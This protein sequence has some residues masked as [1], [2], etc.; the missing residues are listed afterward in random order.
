MEYSV[1]TALYNGLEYTKAYLK[2]LEE[3]MAGEDY[4]LILID[5]CS[6]DGTREFLETLRDR[7]KTKIFLNK[8]NMGFARSNNYAAS[9]A[10]GKLLLLLNNDIILTPGWLKPMHKAIRRKHRWMDHKRQVSVVGNIQKRMDDGQ[11]DHA[12]VYLSIYTTP[13]HAF[14]N[15]ETLPKEKYTPWAAATAA[16]WLVEAEFFRSLGGFDERYVNGMEDV[17]FCL[18]ALEKGRVAVVANQSIIQHAVSASRVGSIED[19]NN[20]RKLWEKWRYPLHEWSVIDQARYTWIQSRVSK[21]FWA[22]LRGTLCL[23]LALPFWKSIEDRSTAFIK[24]PD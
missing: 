21:P 3:T 23:K 7:P 18:Q 17:D 19:E 24:K 14:Q 8:E 6:T 16:C 13:A 11:I 5:D 9:K 12:G 10:E 2:S 1:V 4:E 22:K 15:A 20:Y